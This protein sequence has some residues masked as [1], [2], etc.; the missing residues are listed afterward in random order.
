MIAT[1]RA[2]TGAGLLL[3]HI[4]PERWQPARHPG[5][6][7]HELLIGGEGLARG[8]ADVFTTLAHEAAHALAITRQIADT[9]RDGRYHNQR[10]KQLAHELGLHVQHDVQQGW[11]TTSLPPPPARTT[12]DDHAS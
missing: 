2:G 5:E 3:G 11:S 12:T 1:A 10:Y 4:A 8:A 7:V 6:L 9:S